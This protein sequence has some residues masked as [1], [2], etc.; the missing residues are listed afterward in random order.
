MTMRIVESEYEREQLIRFIEGHSLPFTATLEKGRHRTVEQ[1]KL[2]R[3]W[4]SEIAEQLGDQ[5]PEEV[6]GFCKLT[7]GVPILRQE[8]DDFRAKYD[9]VVRPLPYPQKLAI[10]MEPL[11]MPVTRLMTTR[12]K[13]AYL[14]AVFQRFS[15][16]GLVLT[17]PEEK[18]LKF[19]RLGTGDRRAAA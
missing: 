8:N 19:K 1:N 6:R 14:D 5:T 15:E 9:A 16:M 10:M 12:Q 11:D 13:T 2:Q 3:K 18:V 7:L 17:I 4:M